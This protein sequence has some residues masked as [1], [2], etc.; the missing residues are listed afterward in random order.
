MFDVRDGRPDVVVHDDRLDDVE[1][2][3]RLDAR[4]RDRRCST[5]AVPA[6]RTWTSLW[7]SRRPD[8]RHAVR[9]ERG[10]PDGVHEGG[11]SRP[12]ERTTC[13]RS[14]RSARPVRRCS[15]EA[16]A[17]STTRSSRRLAGLDERRDR[18]RAARSSAAARCCRST[19]GSSRPRS[20]AHASRRSMR[21][22]RSVVGQTGELVL[23]APL[24]SMPVLFWNDPDGAA[25]PREL[26][27]DVP[28][29][30]APRRLDPDHGARQ[31]GHRGPVGFDPQPAG[32]PVRDERAVRR[33]RARARGRSTASS[34]AWS[35]PM[36]RTGC[37]CSWSS[38]PGSTWTPR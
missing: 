22:G 26:L 33:R 13:R 10:V 19:P 5:T 20:W 18:R 11:D 25:L 2:P 21:P 16:S 17:G 23:T 6:I 36:G 3:R 30:L 1:L 24:P 9:D 38:P 8:R 31:R 14:L 12:G 37:R 32:H 27:R 7:A 28:G 29:R 35:C 34:S 15:V 4:R